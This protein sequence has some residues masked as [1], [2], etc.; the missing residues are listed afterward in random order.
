MVDSEP[1]RNVTVELFDIH[2]MEGIYTYPEFIAKLADA[3]KDIPV[4][5]SD[6][7]VEIEYGWSDDPTIFSA[8]YMRAETPEEIADRKAHERHEAE[9]SEYWQRAEYERLKRIYER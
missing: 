8:Y 1:A 4:A 9:R 3:V 7:T 2:D 5:L 6:V